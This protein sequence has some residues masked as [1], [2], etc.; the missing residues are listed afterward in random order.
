MRPAL[1]G[2]AAS[3]R[4]VPADRAARMRR[5]AGRGPLCPDAGGR[6]PAEPDGAGL[7]QR[8]PGQPDGLP[9]GADRHLHPARAPMDHRPG[10]AGQHR[11]P[12]LPRLLPLDLGRARRGARH[13]AHRLHRLNFVELFGAYLLGRVLV[14]DAASHRHFVRSML[15][16]LVLLFPIALIEF[17]TGYK[18]L[19]RLF[20]PIMSMREEAGPMAQQRLGFTR[21]ATSFSHPIHFGLFGSVIFANAYFLLLARPG[22]DTDRRQR[23]RGLRHHAGDLLGRAVLAG[24][25]DRDD[26]LGPGPRLPARPL[27]DRG[28]ARGWR[29]SAS[30][31][32]RCRAGSSTTSSRT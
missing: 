27:V 18:V 2:T 23:L 21:A 16:L 10:R 6:L 31:S 7:L 26:H 8:R 30:C 1:R 9:G 13:V 17:L 32:F 12:A 20:S 25:A 19:Q 5:R 15:L 14:R 3:A 29:R 11:R 22:A 28:R 24:A 4:A